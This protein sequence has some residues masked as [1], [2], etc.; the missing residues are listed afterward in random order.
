MMKTL[1]RLTVLSLLA[2]ASSFAGSIFNVAIDTSTIA[3]TTGSI[4][5]SLFGFGDSQAATAVVSGFT[6]TAP[7]GSVVIEQNVAGSLE[8]A[9][10]LSYPGGFSDASQLRQISFGDLFQFTVALSTT[11]GEALSFVVGIF[12]DEGFDLLPGNT[13]GPL[14]SLDYPGEGSDWN[15]NLNAQEGV[16]SISEVPEPGALGLAG[17]GLLAVGVIR[18]R[19]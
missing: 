19:R 3:G 18:L 16:V 11:P 9:L 14:I 1:L 7:L 17:L 4:Y 2:V 10:T 8:T 5:F 12:D 15:P 13:E 6:P